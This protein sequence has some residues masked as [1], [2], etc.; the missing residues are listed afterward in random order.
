[1]IFHYL[2]Q[3]SEVREFNEGLAVAMTRKRPRQAGYIDRNFN[4]VI[5]LQFLQAQTFR[6]GAGYV[7]P[8]FG[9]E[10]FDE[11][12]R[13]YIYIDR[14]GREVLKP[15]GGRNDPKP[16]KESKPKRPEIIPPLRP[17]RKPGEGYNAPRGYVDPE[18]RWVISP[19]YQQAYEFRNGHARVRFGRHSEGIINTRG[20]DVIGP[21][22]G[23]FGG[24]WQYDDAADELIEGR[25]WAKVWAAGKKPT[26]NKYGEVLSDLAPF[27]EGRALWA[28][29]DTQRGRYPV[30]HAS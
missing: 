7:L 10:L 20:I 5:P 15:T 13:D 14:Q 30:P 8:D 3:F 18:D 26:D 16:R 2:P 28:I 29:F 27:E 9:H 4:V 17:K 24:R 23:Y 12:K 11:E 19:R 6:N 21:I 25:I 1:A 22:E